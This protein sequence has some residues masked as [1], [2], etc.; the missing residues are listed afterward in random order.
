MYQLKSATVIRPVEITPA[1]SKRNERTMHQDRQLSFLQLRDTRLTKATPSS[2]S[3]PN[4][5]RYAWNCRNSKVRLILLKMHQNAQF[6]SQTWLLLG[7]RETQISTL[8]INHPPILDLAMPLVIMI[9]TMVTFIIFITKNAECRQ[10]QENFALF[11]WLIGP[12]TQRDK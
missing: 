1:F 4:A 7:S 2:Y 3:G 8:T 6:L 12:Y 10:S 5:R 9:I 11:T